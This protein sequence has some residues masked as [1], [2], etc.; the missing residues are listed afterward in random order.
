MCDLLVGTRHYRIN[1][2]SF[3]HVEVN[4]IICFANKLTALPIKTRGFPT[5]S[6]EIEMEHWGKMG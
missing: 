4:Q 1:A 3:D 5:F 2:Q 6:G